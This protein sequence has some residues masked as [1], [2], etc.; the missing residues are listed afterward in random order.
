VLSRNLGY[1]NNVWTRGGASFD[2]YQRISDNVEDTDPLFVDEANLDLS[3]G[4][5]S[6][7]SRIPGFEPIPFAEI[8]LV[9]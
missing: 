4:P 1:R 2:H 5:G 7:A 9:P 3:L 8:G 6:P